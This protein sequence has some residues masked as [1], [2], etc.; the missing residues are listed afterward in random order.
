MKWKIGLVLLAAFIVLSLPTLQALTVGFDT[1]GDGQKVKAVLGVIAE[2]FIN[3]TDFWDNLDTPADILIGQLGDVDV[4]GV[5][6]GQVLSFNA[7]SGN[8]EA[9][10]VGTIAGTNGTLNNTN[11]A[12]TN[13]TNIFTEDQDIIGNLNVTGNLTARFTYGSMW[14]ENDTGFVIDITTAGVPVNITNLQTTYNNGFIF[15][16]SH[17]LTAETQGIY[18]ISYLMAMTGGSNKEYRTN[19]IVDGQ[20]IDAGHAHHTST[21][22]SNVNTIGATF[23]TQI[24]ATQEMYLE[25]Q[26]DNAGI[27]DPTYVQFGLTIDRVDMRQ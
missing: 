21:G 13:V 8:W 15:D 12:Y 6:G 2:T 5:T 9:V 25:I 16:G 10:D 19:F 14:Q 24:N 18:K 7:G 22:V 4:A 1:D 27:I 26:Q 3:R 11:I 17:V 20:S 23:Y